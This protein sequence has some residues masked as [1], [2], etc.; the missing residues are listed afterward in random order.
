MDCLLLAF[1]LV[2]WFWDS[3]WELKHYSS[4]LNRQHWYVIS[5]CVVFFGF[6]CLRG[7]KLKI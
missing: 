4:N 1:S 3:W 5:G 6:L 7:N 2:D